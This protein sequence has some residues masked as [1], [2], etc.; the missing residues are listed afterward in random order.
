M[1]L[2]IL[3]D[4]DASIAEWIRDALEKRG[5]AERT[6]GD[7]NYARE[8]PAIYFCCERIDDAGA[9]NDS[10]EPWELELNLVL[11]PGHR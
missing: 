4:K 5:R 11:A 7:D 8:T 9:G 3:E 6:T 10:L 2:R 1:L